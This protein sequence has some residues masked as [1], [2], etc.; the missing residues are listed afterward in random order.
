MSSATN[1]IVITPVRDEE[2]YVE[3]TILSMISQT[4]KPKRWIIVDD[5]SQDRT[6]DIINKYEKQYSWIQSVRLKR[7]TARQPGG[8]VIVAFN[9]GYNLVKEEV[10]DFIVKLDCDLR[11]DPDYFEK[12]F[13]GLDQDD[14]IGI[15]SGIYLEENDDDWS[16]IDMPAYHAAGASKIIRAECFRQIGGFITAKGWDTVDEIKAQTAGWKTCHFKDVV[17]YHLKKEG[18]GIGQVKTNIMHGEIYYLTGG[19]RLF[20]LF[21]AIHRMFLGHPFLVGGIMMTCGYFRALISRRK[22]LVTEKEAA[23]YRQLLNRRLMGRFN[24]NCH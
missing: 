13:I 5:G 8:A 6:G 3:Q 10:F 4:A 2:S 20:F 11:F 22:L 12:I 14:K 23:F 15:A 18:T 9:E 24:F 7:N 16:P 1:Y 17:F 21:K 19:S